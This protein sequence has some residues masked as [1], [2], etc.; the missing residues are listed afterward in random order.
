MLK[1]SLSVMRNEWRYHWHLRTPLWLLS[2]LVVLWLT[3]GMASY[4]HWQQH[5]ENIAA[6]TRQSQHDWQ[7]QPDRHPHRVSHFGDFVA[8]PMHPLSMLEPGI[9]DQSG[10]LVYLEAHRLNSANFNPA[11]EATSLG[12]FPLITPAQ[13]VQWWLPLFMIMIGYDTMTREKLGGSLLFMR[14]NG[15]HAGQIALGKALALFLP[16]LALVT[17]QALLA[18]VL[19]WGSTELA[20]RLFTLWLGETLYI[21]VWGLLIVAVSWASRQLHSALLALLLLWV[22]LCMVLPRGLANLAQTRYPTTARVTAEYQAEEKLKHIGNSHNPDDPHF[23]QFKA[24][25]L[26]RYGVEK[27]EDLPVNYQGLL[28]QEGERLTTALYRE[29]QAMH[30]QQLLKQNAF[31]FHWCWLS[32][33]LALQYLHM[34]SSGSDLAHHQAFLTQSEHRRYALIQYLNQIHT[35]VVSQANDKNTRVSAEFWKKAPRPAITLAPLQTSINALRTAWAVLLIWLLI[36]TAL[37]LKS[38]H[39]L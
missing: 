11:T 20:P 17:L 32:P 5:A 31:I 10:H 28:M 4:Q 22:C 35:Q 24:E 36:A 27:V 37:L 33:A 29:Q 16:F 39:R 15:I 13:V 19:C 7:D 23:A 38:L 8:K 34:A 2:V 3:A 14:G 21:A 18:T 9:S 26:R 12:R 6:V 25:T 1:V 30:D